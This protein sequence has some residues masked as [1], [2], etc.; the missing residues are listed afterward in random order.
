MSEISKAAGLVP[1]LE[2]QLDQNP[3]AV[4]LA[5]LSPGSRPAVRGAL[6][7]IGEILMPG[8]S[9]Y[10]VPWHSLRYQHTQAIKSKLAQTRYAPSTANKMLYFLR[11]VL[12]EAWRLGLMPVEEYHRAVDVGKIPGAKVPSGR[13]LGMAEIRALFASCDPST[14]VGARDAALLSLLYGGGLRRA[15][16]VGLRMSDVDLEAETIKVLGKGG[17]ERVVYMSPGALAAIQAWIEHRGTEAGAFLKPVAK[18][19]RIRDRHMSFNGVLKRLKGLAGQAG[20]RPFSAHDF[21]RTYIG[22]LL[23]AGVDLV[24]IQGLAGHASVTTTAG[25]DRRG[26]RAKKR[27]AGMLHVPFGKGEG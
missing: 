11:G 3:V 27:A 24:A 17:K 22:D 1:V 26:E 7:V 2:G 25:Y 5:K 9:I 21:R 8:V 15:E 6:H 13:A 23:D 16:A 14:P 10:R 18:G 20:V 19:G 12:K 4:Y